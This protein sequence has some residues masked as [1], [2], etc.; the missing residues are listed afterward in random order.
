LAEKQSPA[1][2]WSYHSVIA[3][4]LHAVSV[5]V[6]RFPIFSMR[7]KDMIQNPTPATFGS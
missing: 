7:M 6:F 5:P 1:V 4:I 2:G 3:S